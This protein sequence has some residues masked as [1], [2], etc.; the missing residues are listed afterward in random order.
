MT[1]FGRRISGLALVLLASLCVNAFALAAFAS[2]R[3]GDRP[4]RPPDGPPF[5]RIVRNAPE[6]MRPAMRQGIETRRAELDR[7]LAAM[8]ETRQEIA[9]ML[10]EPQVDRDSLDKAF[11]LLRERQVAIQGVLHAALAEA[12]ASAPVE[13][14]AAWAERWGERR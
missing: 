11:D 13:T 4:R 9:R 1:L 7:R 8:R 14:R 12:L 3:F 2:H 5:D 6:A 10:R